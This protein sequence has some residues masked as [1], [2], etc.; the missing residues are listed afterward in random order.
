MPRSEHHQLHLVART[1]HEEPRRVD[2]PKGS[3]HATADI[4]KLS[5]MHRM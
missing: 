2:V 4:T 3:K 1:H 5:D